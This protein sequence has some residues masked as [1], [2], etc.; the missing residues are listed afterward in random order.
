M[1]VAGAEFR[2]GRFAE[3]LAH[4]V[5]A[6]DAARGL[7][8]PDLLAA[9]ALTVH[10]V[11]APGFAPAVLAMCER[12]LAG[13][14]LSPVVRARLLAQMAS[15]HAD[16]GRL[17][18]SSELSATALELAE[19]T[20]DPE[21][22]LDAVRARMKV[23]VDALPPDERLRLGRLAIEHA[24][25]T[26]QPL[27]EL[28]GAKWR[29]D[30]ALETGDLTTTEAELA[31][32][33]ALARRTGLPLVR[34]HDLRLRASVAAL[35]GRFPEALALNAQ[36]RELGAREL[37]QDVSTAGMSGAFAMQ[38]AQIT[39]DMSSW[40]DADLRLLDL[41]DEVP[42]VLVSRALVAFL[43][44]DRDDAR[45]RYEDVRRRL[46]D[47]DFAASSGVPTNLVPL[48]EA[49]EDPATAEV[50]AGLIAARPIAAGGAGV[51]CC[52]SMA[53]LLG[54]LEI[55]RG[56]VDHAIAYF[57]EALAVDTGTGARPAVVHDRL[58]L[59]GALLRRGRDEDLARAGD[60]ARAAR[61]EA[62]RLGMPGPGPDR[63]APRGRGRRRTA[64][65]RSADRARAG[66]R[67]AGRGRAHQPADRG[68]AGALG[69]HG[70]EPRAQHP[71]Q[72]GCGQPHGDRTAGLRPVLAR[73]DHEGGPRATGQAGQRGQCHRGAVL[74]QRGRGRRHP[75]RRPP[76]PGGA[77]HRTRGGPDHA[78]RRRQRAVGAGPG[79]QPGTALEPAQQ[80]RGQARPAE[81]GRSP[82]MLVGDQ[83]RGQG[84]RRRHLG[85]QGGPARSGS[86]GRGEDRPGEAQAAAAPGGEPEQAERSTTAAP[87]GRRGVRFSRSVGAASSTA[88]TATP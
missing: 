68:P 7:A 51:Y 42:I 10:D 4:A 14:G 27:V 55:V 60:L 8:R 71:D 36:A 87:A 62:V 29:I 12:A 75:G 17:A 19:G 82:R 30:A 69:A 84:D 41:A 64:G 20:G 15:F 47:P 58:G 53:G 86:P 48:V 25:V 61:Q 34:W 1:E 3:S 26:G 72:A 88:C 2:A 79:R 57:E 45:V 31:R 78:R 39:G 54:R 22:I 73:H 56:R 80:P 52:G 13:P 66:D 9:A 67:R 81:P 63:G 70:G 50:L 35:V 85:R 43:R 28:W 76:S 38:H 18:A 32:I 37:A 74:E 23:T 77:G 46:A 49:F 5:A 6:S 83:L 44:G 24:A 16:A 65:G 59:A 40:D 11:A 33:S 21:A